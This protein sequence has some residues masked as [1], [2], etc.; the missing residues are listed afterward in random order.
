[1]HI[2]KP[3]TKVISLSDAAYSKL[4]AAKRTGE[5]FSDVTLRVLKQKPLS[6]FSGVWNIS[7]E[8]ATRIKEKL[9]RERKEFK[10]R[11]VRI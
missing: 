4:K 10:L 1:M 6:D 2:D 11:E 5:S 7:D 8:E 9:R 3:M